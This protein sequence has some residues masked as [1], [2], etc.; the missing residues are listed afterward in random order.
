MRPGLESR[1]GLN[2]ETALP[3][4]G[5]AVRIRED[6]L[7]RERIT[8][9]GSIGV[10]GALICVALAAAVLSSGGS[11]AGPLAL[12]AVAAAV[13]YPG[14][15]LLLR[16]FRSDAPD[17]Y[18]WPVTLFAYSVLCGLVW[19]VTAYTFLDPSYANATLI[20]LGV[21]VAA[22]TSWQ[23]SF[24][25]SWWALASFNALAFGA[26]AVRLLIAGESGAIG[27]AALLTL[28]GGGLFLLAYGFGR[29]LVAM[30][31][32]ALHDPLTGLPNR[33]LFEDR[34]EM[35]TA[36]SRRRN[37]MSAVLLLDLDNFKHVNDGLG[38]TIGDKLL[39][40]VAKRLTAS[41]RAVDTV[42]RLGG[43]EFVTIL[44]GIHESR[45]A[46][47]LGRRIATAIAEPVEVEGHTIH[48]SATIGIALYPSDVEGTRPILRNADLALYRAKEHQ[49]GTIEFYSEE[50]GQEAAN[51]MT[52]VEQLKKA[53][54]QGQLHF[55]YQPQFDARDGVL[56]GAE[57]LLRWHSPERG[58]VAPGIFIPV[59]ETS[60]LMLALGRWVLDSTCRRLRDW[61]DAGLPALPVS[62]NLSGAQFRHASLPKELRTCLSQSG[63]EPSL[64]QLEV[65]EAT[66]MQDATSATGILRDIVATGVQV[67]IDDFGTGFF[68]LNHLKQ[69]PIGKL[70]IDGSF[71]RNI[72]DNE[73]DAAIARA[74]TQLGHSL[75]LEVLAEG[76]ES[77]LQ[78]DK[79]REIGA[80]QVQGFLLSMPL[81]ADAFEALLREQAARAASA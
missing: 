21:V 70:K 62:V 16:R 20:L 8:E 36:A 12:W 24:L 14:G 41:V 47:L 4:G 58:E 7:T 53:L 76:V 44:T 2:V 57:A 61:H 43:D 69:I 32:M 52:L 49:R 55:V 80:D 54:D 37:N 3:M 29:H 9:E 38:H 78:L 59:A 66:L 72:G 31:F 73:Q 25:S 67:S 75:G 17:R 30:E 42:A 50:L 63:I 13:V 48:T 28:I 71:V 60:G 15:Y 11:A 19:A 6:A 34:L 77:R 65:T 23:W 40:A 22:A 51:R 81:E 33:A 10:I 68:S 74:I 56:V 39:Q 45:Q 1:A 64:L 18:R 5:D 26:F 35:A 79:L 27:L 46:L